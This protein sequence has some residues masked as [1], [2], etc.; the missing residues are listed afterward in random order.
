MDYTFSLYKS[1][2]QTVGQLHLNC[3]AN[4]LLALLKPVKASAKEQLPLLRFVANPHRGSPEYTGLVLDLDGKHKHHDISEL[5]S[6][7]SNVQYV[8]YSTW[9]HTPDAPRWRVVLPFS[10]KVSAEQK[11]AIGQ[12]I[13]DTYQL[14]I[15]PTS[16][17]NPEIAQF[18]PAKHVDD[19][20]FKHSLN[21]SITLDQL[22]D[23]QTLL[24]N[25]IHHESRR[26]EEKKHQL[27]LVSLEGN[28]V[29]FKTHDEVKRFWHQRSVQLDI[30]RSVFGIPEQYLADG[31][32][33]SEHATKS[34]RSV[35]AGHEDRKPSCSLL[36]S[37][38]RS[39]LLKDFSGYVDGK[40]LW[41]YEEILYQQTV[42]KISSDRQ[43]SEVFLAAPTRYLWRLRV[44]NQAGLIKT[45]DIEFKKL[46]KDTVEPAVVEVY[47]AIKELFLLRWSVEE[48]FGCPAPIS[49]RF[50]SEW[51]GLSEHRVRKARS[52]LLELGFVSIVEEYKNGAKKIQLCAPGYFRSNKEKYDYRANPVKAIE[53][54]KE[55]HS[56]NRTKSPEKRYIAL[57]SAPNEGLDKPHVV[58]GEWLDKIDVPHNIYSECSLRFLLDQF[59]NMDVLGVLGSPGEFVKSFEETMKIRLADSDKDV[60]YGFAVE[61]YPFRNDVRRYQESVGSTSVG[62]KAE[63][64]NQQVHQALQRNYLDRVGRS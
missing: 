28:Q 59:V 14:D 17:R 41:G 21:A 45:P 3:S 60:V 7:F 58:L 48:E 49:I 53:R 12:Y 4:Q 55:L 30:A 13:V 10:Q 20:V 5:E 40:D 2:Y 42:S 47:E 61:S 23:V 44:L 38:G 6:I 39:A 26:L 24:Q 64:S 8:I 1:K 33:S 9:S 27:K 43:T 15:D 54:D 35:L 11:R 19:P 57:E 63:S 34:F 29:C 56:T 32:E 62:S 50:I 36:F 51:A 31:Y 46:P 22:P 16:Y 25:V 18:V 52:K 37:E